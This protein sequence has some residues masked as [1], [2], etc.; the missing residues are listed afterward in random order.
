MF[1]IRTKLYQTLM[2][3]SKRSSKSAP[4]SKLPLSLQAAEVAALEALVQEPGY[5]VLKT[6]LQEL[7]ETVAVQTLKPIS[8]EE[9]NFVRGRLYAFR[10]MY[11]IV[12]RIIAK[13]H[14]LKDE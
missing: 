12:E 10:E 4:D 13:K 9:A 8:L 1:E 14:Q 2:L 5:S 7:T 3:F 11:D 6:V